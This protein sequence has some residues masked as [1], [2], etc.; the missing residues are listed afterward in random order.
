M[1]LAL[2]LRGEARNLILPEADSDPPSFRKAVK[3][4]R[5]RFGEPKNPSYHVAQMR[6]RKR[7]E[8]ETVP[9]LAQWFK[10]MGLKA[11]PAERASTRDRIL[12]DTFVRSLPDEQQ[13]CYIWDKEPEGLEDAVS[14]ALRYEGIRHTEDQANYE[15]IGH[16]ETANRKT[17]AVTTELEA[18]R[19]EVDELRERQE[20]RVTAVVATETTPKVNS[21]VTPNPNHIQPTQFT[22]F[23]CGRSGHFA[24]DCKQGTKC[25]Y[26]QKLGHLVKDCRKRQYDN[27]R[28]GQSGPFPTNVN[29]NFPRPNYQPSYQGNGQG[30]GPVG[31]TAGQRQ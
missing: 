7:K 19:K 23:N 18:L 12:L 17:R 26:C 29:A 21:N 15:A 30:R 1:E 2:R 11:Y 20:T 25:H 24:K 9:E 4:L 16:K 14:A 8:K 27:N 31:A 6:A 3:Q 28:A 22:C 10:K 5:E 13:R